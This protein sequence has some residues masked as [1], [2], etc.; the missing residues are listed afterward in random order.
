VAISQEILQCAKPLFEEHAGDDNFAYTFAGTTFAASFRNHIFL[1]TAN[2]VLRRM[3]PEAARVWLSGRSLA[4]NQVLRPDATEESYGDLAML[5]LDLNSLK[6]GELIDLHPIN[7]DAQF[8]CSLNT[9]LPN[10]RLVVVGYPSEV[11]LEGQGGTQEVSRHRLDFDELKLNLT[12]YSTD[13]SYGGQ[14]EPGVHLV[15]Y[16]QGRRPVRNHDGLSGAP[17]IVDDPAANRWQHK[18]AGIHVMGGN[19]EVARFIGADVLVGMLATRY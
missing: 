3:Q 17:W 10:S 6:P 4:F 11:F 9:L 18:L 1:I 16:Y 7:L 2:H 12:P 8:G 5:E 15:C 14:V 19:L 13:A